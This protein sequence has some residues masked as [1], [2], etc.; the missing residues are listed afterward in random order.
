MTSIELLH[1]SAPGVLLSESSR[2]NEHVF[3]TQMS[4]DKFIVLIRGRPISYSSARYLWVRSME[5]HATFW[6]L[7]F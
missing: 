7:E 2:T 4:F 1:C 5:L 6:P 3:N